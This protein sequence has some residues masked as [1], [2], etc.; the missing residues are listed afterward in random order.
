VGRLHHIL[1]QQPC[2]T[3][4]QHLHSHHPTQLLHKRSQLF[5]R[6]RFNLNGYL[7]GDDEEP[8]SKERYFPS[9]KGFHDVYDADGVGRAGTEG[10]TCIGEYGDQDVLLHVEGA[11]VEGEAPG[12]EPGDPEGGGGEERRHEAADGE[13]GDL[14]GDLTDDKWLGP[15]GEEL[16]EE[17]QEGAGEQTQEPH[18][19]GPYRL[20]RVIGVTHR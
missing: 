9:I 4:S 19:E 7:S 16:V 14:H 12:P 1:P 8:R 3:V 11:R 13:R 20:G 10:A 5:Q 6:E 18:S 2:P 17:G 15:V